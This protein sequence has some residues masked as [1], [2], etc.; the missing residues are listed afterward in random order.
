MSTNLK[1][2]ASFVHQIGSIM[3]ELDKTKAELKALQEKQASSL[4]DSY[5]ITGLEVDLKYYKKAWS[6]ACAREVKLQAEVDALKQ[7]Q[8]PPTWNS[9]CFKE[10][11]GV[12]QN[13]IGLI[14]ELHTRVNFPGG[15]RE[16]KEVAEGHRVFHTDA[17]PVQVSTDCSDWSCYRKF[18]SDVQTLQEL[19]TCAR[20]NGYQIHF[21]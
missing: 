9:F 6:D 14:K 12:Q 17:T 1:I 19:T 8:V 3:L 20:D 21:S 18:G 5:K 15:L 10:I 16:A 7:G 13:K 4:Q 11:P 2:D